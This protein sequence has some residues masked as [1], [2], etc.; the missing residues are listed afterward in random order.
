[1]SRYNYS[2]PVVSFADRTDFTRTRWTDR[3]YNPYA[4]PVTDST[5]KITKLA[6]PIPY[7]RDREDPATEIRVRHDI[8]RGF[9]VSNDT[10][11]LGRAWI[12]GKL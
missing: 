7:Y 9:E 2:T 3:S 1:M 6:A 4:H 10:L 8:C 11:A 5:E 12:K